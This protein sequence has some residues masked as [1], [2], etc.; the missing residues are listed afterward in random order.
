MI[1]ESI[2]ERS[3]TRSIY[4]TSKL[5]T[6]DWEEVVFGFACTGVVSHVHHEA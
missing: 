5:D 2:L 1:Y 4:F 3:G 6:K